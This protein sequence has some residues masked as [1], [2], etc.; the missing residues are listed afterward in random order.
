[1]A[2]PINEGSVST[3]VSSQNSQQA[4]N[5]EPS[6]PTGEPAVS[7]PVPESPWPEAL[8]ESADPQVEAVLATLKRI[9]GAPLPEHPAIYTQ[10]HDALLAELNA[11]PV[12]PDE[13]DAGEGETH[14]QA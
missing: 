12:D 6:Q 14:A 10:L 4:S 2:T 8:R 9:P 5:Q 1:M 7:S 11:V 3:Q 13:A